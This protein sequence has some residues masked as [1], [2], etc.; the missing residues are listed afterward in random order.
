MTRRIRRRL[1]KDQINPF[2]LS[3]R[4]LLETWLNVRRNG[5]FSLACIAVAAISLLVFGI[6][7]LI[8]GSLNNLV[9]SF[10]ERVGVSAYLKSTVTPSQ[11]AWLQSKIISWPEVQAVDYVSS[12]EA[13]DSL[14]KDLSGFEDVLSSLSV[15]PL[16]AS[17][18]IKPKNPDATSSIVEQLQDLE[19]IEEVQYDAATVSKLV[20]FASFFRLLGVII[21]LLFVFCTWF[22]LSSAIRMTVYARKIEIEVMKLV[23][24]TDSYIKYPFITEGIFYGLVGAALACI[25]LLPLRT[26][27]IAGLQRVGFLAHIGPDQTFLIWVILILLA[28]GSSLGALSANLSVRRFL[29]V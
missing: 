9:R 17:L 3:R 4:V 25:L 20:A 14:K 23:G 13:M 16:P 10:E 2:R 22:L 6:F 11:A 24:A 21:S 28:L 8:D 29:R 1:Y 19:D 12:V 5:A 27:L 26:V 15:N 7:L 18:E